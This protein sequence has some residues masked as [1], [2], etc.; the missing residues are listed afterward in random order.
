MM[1]QTLSSV[2]CCIDRFLLEAEECA[3]REYGFASMLTGFAVMLAVSEAVNGRPN[4][5]DLLSWFISRM[6]ED[7]D[8]IVLPLN[9]PSSLGLV[10][11]KLIELRDSLAHQLSMPCDVLLAGDRTSAE[12]E[13]QRSPGKYIIITRQF[14]DAIRHTVQRIVASNPET[15]L[16]PSIH[17]RRIQRAAA[18]RL[19]GR[20]GSPGLSG[21]PA[22]V[23]DTILDEE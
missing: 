9:V 13:A 4:N 3:E 16:D 2:R 5:R 10:T 21:T 18:T 11:N 17:R 7:R 6:G 20:T 22:W 14:V 23:D 15:T 1:P 19:E 8:W 12:R